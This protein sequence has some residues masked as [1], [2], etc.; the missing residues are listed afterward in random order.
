MNGMPRDAV[1]T[2]QFEIDL[3]RIEGDARRADEFI[4]GVEWAI[5]R[6]PREGRR[7]TNDVWAW[8]RRDLPGLPHLTVFYTFNDQT[9]WLL[10][11]RTFDQPDIED[12]F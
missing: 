10:A 2:E 6:N 7:V 12:A 9:V 3:E 4:R 8:P 1:Y 11:I 5:C